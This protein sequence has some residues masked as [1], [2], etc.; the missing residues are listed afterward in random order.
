MQIVKQISIVI[1]NSPGTLARICRALEEAGINLSGFAAW[2]EQDH[3]IVRVVCDRPLKAL[4]LVEG[5]G[6]IAF[7]SEILEVRRENRPG[8]LLEIAES[9]AND[10]VNIDYAYGSAPATGAGTMYLG[11]SDMARARRALKI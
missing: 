11:V 3:G 7:S 9:L 6:M 4:D 10:R 8:E 2:G 5:A 1:N